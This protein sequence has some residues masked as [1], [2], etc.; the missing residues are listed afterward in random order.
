MFVRDIVLLLYPNYD[1]IEDKETL[2]KEVNFISEYKEEILIQQREI[3]INNPGIGENAAMRVAVNDIISRKIF[4]KLHPN[5]SDLEFS[6][7]MDLLMEKDVIDSE[8]AS[9]VLAYNQE[10][11]KF[12]D[13]DKLEILSKVVED[14]WVDKL[15]KERCSGH[16]SF[17]LEETK[18]EKEYI[19]KNLFTIARGS[20]FKVDSNKIKH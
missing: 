16:E 3:L 14:V 19:R 5:F 2:K 20:F 10:E 13:K 1:D 12:P 9:I 11:K 15:F 6:K 17:S 18:K 4:K 8:I 7:Q